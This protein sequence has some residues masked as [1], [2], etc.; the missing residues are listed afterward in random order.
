MKGRITKLTM[1]MNRL[2]ILLSVLCVSAVQISAATSGRGPNLIVI[3]A[4]DIG[5]GS[6]RA[7]PRED[8]EYTGGAGWFGAFS[9]QYKFVVS[10]AAAPSLFDLENDPNELTNLLDSPA[11]RETVRRVAGLRREVQRPAPAKRQ[12]P[13]RPRLGGEGHRRLSRA[14][15]H[16]RNARES[17][18]QGEE[19][20]EERVRPS[21]E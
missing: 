10:P 13:R 6:K 2:L 18:G 7:A 15:S 12:R 3:M 1:A 4:D 9:R 17:Q 20:Q 8:G 5:G 11:Q 21:P 16:R 14:L 19:E